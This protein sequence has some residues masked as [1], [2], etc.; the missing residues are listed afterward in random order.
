M[1]FNTPINNPNCEDPVWK[2][3]YIENPMWSDSYTDDY[4]KIAE[5]DQ[6][7]KQHNSSFYFIFAFISLLF[8]GVIFYI[9]FF[10]NNC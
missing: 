1:S 6:C 10:C 5:E 2:D 7:C 3:S 8:C 4:I 9:L